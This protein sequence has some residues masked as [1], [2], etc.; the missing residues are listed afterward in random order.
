[1]ADNYTDHE[2]SEL[3]RKQ[4]PPQPIPPE[5][6]QRITQRV[7]AEVAMMRESQLAQEGLTQSSLPQAVANT[8]PQPVRRSVRKQSPWAQF[9]A[10]L[11]SR[12]TFAPSLAFSIATAAVVLFVVLYGRDY[13]GGLFTTLPGEIQTGSQGVQTLPD[14]ELELPTSSAETAVAEISLADTETPTELPAA[15]EPTLDEG[16]V[17]T[18][19]EIPPVSVESSI[20]PTIASEGEDVSSGMPELES[21]QEGPE[22][23]VPGVPPNEPPVSNEPIIVEDIP[24]TRTPEPN[25]QVILPTP[26]PDPLLGSGGSTPNPTNTNSRTPTRL[27][28]GNVVGNVTLP[29]RTPIPPAQSGEGDVSSLLPTVTPTPRRT[30]GNGGVGVIPTRTLVAP[31]TPTKGTPT[32]LPGQSPTPVATSTPIT[33]RT[34]VPT[35]VASRPTATVTPRVLMGTPNAPTAT[36]TNTPVPPTWTP[37]PTATDTPIPP[38]FTPVPPTWTPTFTPVPPTFTPT[39]TDTPVPPTFTPTATDTPLPTPTDTPVPPTFTP[40][41]TDTPLP[42]PTDTP[43]PIPTNAPPVVPPYSYGLQGD[44]TYDILR[45]RLLDNAQD[46]NGRDNLQW[47]G[48]ISNQSEQGGQVDDDI[49][50]EGLALV[51]YQPPPHLLA[52]GGEDRFYYM[53]SDSQGASVAGMVIVNVSAVA[54]TATP[55]PTPTATQPPPPPPEG[56]NGGNGNDNGTQD[57]NAAGVTDQGTL[58]E[59]EVISNSSNAP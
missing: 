31:V 52:T 39:A 56:G 44:G 15:L 9:W 10:E 46:D 35:T 57:I 55:S 58:T 38:T 59:T 41:A 29:T 24:P 25:G 50:A 34:G 26:T 11:R 18:D 23:I 22:H 5:L 53:I 27:P 43:V 14:A 45:S 12:L 36:P 8:R 54:P 40:T 2:L 17:P 16:M 30:N 21:A 49:N 28:N 20:P 33:I 37:L 3:F 7:L 48:F 51:K 42:T 6:S 32:R 47:G 19:T 4:L 1:M 13:L